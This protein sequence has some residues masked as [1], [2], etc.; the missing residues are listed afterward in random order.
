[1]E[2]INLENNKGLIEDVILFPLKVNRDKRGILVETLKINWSEIYND[3]RPFTQN[4]FSTTKPGVARD[5]DKWHVHKNQEDRFIVISGNIVV[6]MFDPR[7][8][9]KSYLTLNLFL[10]GEINGDNGQYLLLIP[11][12]V[13]HGFV[14]I[15]KNPAT[16][17]NYPTQLFNPEDE[18]RV[19]HKDSGAKFPDGTNFSWDT[20]RKNF[21]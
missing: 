19:L 1:M 21:R 10:M 11:K 15:G 8:D 12:N 16:L 17:L 6:A 2:Y 18:G 13:M 20:I 5:N 14:V 3:K 7:K 9:K 4:Y